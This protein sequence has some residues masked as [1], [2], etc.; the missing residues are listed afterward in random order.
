MS[1]VKNSWRKGVNAGGCR[2][3]LEK[4]STNPQYLLKLSEPDDVPD[5]PIEEGKCS[6]L[7]GLMQEHRRSEKN[8]PL[9]MLPIGIFIYKASKILIK[10][11]SNLIRLEI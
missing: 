2:N 5:I 11:F 6:V 3:D 8:K 1:V 9:A 4:F 7:L 10:N